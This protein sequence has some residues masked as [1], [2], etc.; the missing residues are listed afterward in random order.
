MFVQG[1]ELANGY[2]ELLDPDELRRRWSAISD[3]RAADGKYALP[4][5]DRLFAAMEHGL[6]PC[7]GVALGFDRLV[8]VAAGAE[9]VAE[10]M[11][12]PVDRA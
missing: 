6:P 12:F 5:S 7:A 1:V 4:G 8:M 3:Q 10:V 11:P 2:H 9:T